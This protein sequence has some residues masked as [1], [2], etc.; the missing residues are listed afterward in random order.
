MAVQAPAGEAGSPSLQRAPSVSAWSRFY[1]LG[2]VY[3]KTLRDSRMAFLIM[4]G[5]LGGIMLYASVAIPAAFPTQESRDGLVKLATD[6]SSALGGITGTPINVGTVGGYIWWKY[7]LSFGLM[8]GLWSIVALSGTLASEARRGSL[9]MVAAA[10]FGKRRIAFEKLAAHVTGMT[11]VAVVI[12]AV[13]YVG[14]HVAGKLPGDA[15]PLSACVGFALWVW[16]IGLVSGSV[17]WALAPFVGR[18]SAAGVAGAVMM[19]GYVAHGF[20]KSAA[21][22][23]ALADLTPFHWTAGHVPLAVQYDWLSLVPVA[24]VAA[25]LFAIGIEAFGR[26]DIGSSNAIPIPAMPQTILGVRGPV[27]RAFGERLPMALA[28]GIGLGI[29]ALVM[30]AASGSLVEAFDKSPDLQRVLQAAFPAYDVASAGGVLQLLFIQMGFIAAGLGAAT[31]AAG[32]ASDETDG[33]LELLLGTPLARGRWA[34]ASGV[35]VFGAIAAMTVVAAAGVTI[36]VAS[37]HGDVVTPAVGSVTLGLYAAAAAG[38]G[39]AFGGL[40]RGSIAGDAAAIAVIATELIDFL[41]PPLN[42][43]DWFHRLALT[44]NM[45]LPMVGQW[46]WAGVVA[47]LAI[48][49]GGLLIGAWGMRRRDV[50]R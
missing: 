14:T 6:T 27:G 23:A 3:A 37:A 11:A 42:L 30:G 7:G 19:G 39:F 1:G 47:C 12:G 41:A 50:A 45:G 44:A 13:T 36:G 28:W 5:L 16:L 21:V 32:W 46:N 25:V 10:P 40:V 35:G 24:I 34:I 29:W 22:L 8:A 38:V 49:V 33:R 17:A 9:D 31:L 48:A 26:R 43:P 20:A 4:V 18:A 2:S 15:L